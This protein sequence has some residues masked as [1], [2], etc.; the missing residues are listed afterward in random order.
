MESIKELVK[1][2]QSESTL[3]FGHKYKQKC[4]WFSERLQY[5]MCVNDGDTAVFR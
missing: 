5:L 4:R 1:M 2:S 3:L